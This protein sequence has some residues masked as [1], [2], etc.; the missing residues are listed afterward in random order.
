MCQSLHHPSAF[1]EHEVRRD[2]HATQDGRVGTWIRQ[3]ERRQATGILDMSEDVSCS[4]YMSAS[5]SAPP[6]YCTP[7]TLDWTALYF[8]VNQVKPRM[9]I[10]L[11]LFAPAPTEINPNRNASI[12]H[13]HRTQGKAITAQ[14]T[15]P[16]SRF[17]PPKPSH[18]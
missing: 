16:S 11:A 13:R 1:I 4:K 5:A 18:E 7:A 2:S 14:K 3:K 12:E 9:A 6:Y 17:S 8:A 10:P 15:P